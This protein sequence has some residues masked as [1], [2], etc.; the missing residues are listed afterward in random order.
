MSQSPMSIRQ[1]G[2]DRPGEELFD[3]DSNLERESSPNT[4]PPPEAD[5]NSTFNKSQRYEED[6]TDDKSAL[7]EKSSSKQS[8]LSEFDLLNVC[9]AKRKHTRNSRKPNRFL[10]PQE[11][12]IAEKRISQS[13]FSQNGTSLLCSKAYKKETSENKPRDL[14][15]IRNRVLRGVSRRRLEEGLTQVKSGRVGLKSML[16]MDCME[17]VFNPDDKTVDGVSM[18]KP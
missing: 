2:F 12:N 8:I 1:S 15:Y 11:P 17:W 16:M 14:F 4:P 6:S 10:E 13:E 18:I 7:H 9:I 3:N 5:T